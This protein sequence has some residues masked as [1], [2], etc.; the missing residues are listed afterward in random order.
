[1]TAT[2]SSRSASRPSTDSCRV[3]GADLERV[4]T[5]AWAHDPT[6]ATASYACTSLGCSYE[7]H[8]REQLTATLGDYTE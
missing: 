3:C 1:M 6:I 4:A 5:E 8:T 7:L 2:P